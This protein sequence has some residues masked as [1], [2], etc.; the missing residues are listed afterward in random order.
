MLLPVAGMPL[1]VLCAKRVLTAGYP[2]VV[3]TSEESSDDLLCAA[4]RDHGIEFI[5]GPLDDVLARFVKAAK[6]MKD[7]DLIVR[8]TGDNPA[9]DG[10]FIKEI[11]KY[12][13][14]SKARYT[15]SF[16]PLDGLP[17]GISAEAIE[18][19]MLRKLDKAKQ[20]A[21]DREHV[22]SHFTR[23]GEYSL[24]KS[25]LGRD[26]SHLRATVDTFSDY[27]RVARL[28]EKTGA[29]AGWQELV[30]ILER[31]PGNPSH[32][33][34]YTM[35]GLKPQSRFALGTVQFGLPYG[36]ANKGG[37]PDKE[38]AREILKT[39]LA[40]GVSMIDTAAAYGT[41]EKVIGACLSGHEKQGV[42]I[43]TKLDPLPHINDRSGE[44]AVRDAVRASIYKS[45][46][47]LG[48]ARL[49]CVMLH[50][51]EHYRLGGGK[52]WRE[53]LALKKNGV[54]G[55]LGASVQS[56]EEGLAALKVAE[57]EFIQLPCNIL[58]WRWRESGFAAKRAERDD[59]HVQAR[60]ALLQGLLLLPAEK[61]PVIG[62]KEADKFTKALRELAEEHAR[63]SVQDLCYAYV[64]SLGW[65]DSIVAGVETLAQ[66]KE[67]L[68]LFNGPELGNLDEVVKR[69]LRADAK[70]LNPAEWS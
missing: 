32:R 31:E 64:R 33:T 60:S 48:L 51:W 5:R 63:K 40:C 18:A 3:A 28:F 10:A 65:V 70:L 20:S 14:K 56:P 19:G 30:K 15:R 61:W 24:F 17:Y 12:H 7:K 25:P 35:K 62:K 4:L 11:V 2:L 54:I 38:E 21:E 8:L 59:V 52:I 68:D 37:Q 9:V 47:H 23:K 43:H 41:A 22:T 55:R 69:I 67:N 13:Q 46:H 26:L 16:S 6:G 29:E 58:D 27:L 36:I 1:I 34:P 53:L 45:C 44:E 42:D 39:A 66:L 49:P 50:R 57:I